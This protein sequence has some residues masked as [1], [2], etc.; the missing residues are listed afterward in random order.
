MRGSS[1]NRVCIY[2]VDVHVHACMS[3]HHCSCVCTHACMYVR[4]YA[5]MLACT[6]H[7]RRQPVPGKVQPPP[8]S[9]LKFSGSSQILWSGPPL[10]DF[11]LLS[12]LPG[13]LL[14][15]FRLLSN[16]PGPLLSDFWAMESE[17]ILSKFEKSSMESFQF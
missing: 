8:R 4:M 3:T 9:P 5:C 14:S 11:R 15:D 2:S 13:P 12:N 10:S 7:Q 1:T 17:R 16:L 6:T